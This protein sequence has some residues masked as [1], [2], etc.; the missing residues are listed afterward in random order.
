M[1]FKKI[2]FLSLIIAFA[3]WILGVSVVKTSAVDNQPS[4][5]NY[6]VDTVNPI[7]LE[8]GTVE[9]TVSAVKK[10][11]DYF[12]VYPGILPDHFLYPIKMIRDRVQLWLTTDHL[13]KGELMLKYADKRLGAGRV[14]IEGNKVELGITTLTKGEK[15][16]QQAIDQ[17]E[18]VN[19]E[20][21]QSFFK[22]LSQ[23]S[24]KHEEVL[25]VLKEKIDSSSGPMMEKILELVRQ[26][27]ERIQQIQ[28]K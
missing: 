3:F 14:L 7:P 23:S 27:Q 25:L 8:K 5:K 19:K 28:L 15:Y 21:A 22:E 26:S 10:E 16:L 1:K 24:L 18:L 6:K 12:L 20:E 17:G 2:T 9:S 4:S 13:A 11:I